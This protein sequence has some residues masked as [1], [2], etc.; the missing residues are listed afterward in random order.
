MIKVLK[1]F[2]IKK[3]IF[4]KQ[5]RNNF[6]IENNRL[7]YKYKLN[8][9]TILN[10]KISFKEEIIPLL[11]NTINNHCGYKAMCNHIIIS[12]FYWEGYSTDIRKFIAKCAY[13]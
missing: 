6:Y 9:N 7:I 4:L 1:S 8:S 2:W 13:I 11:Q 3:L 10:G 5:W 12:G